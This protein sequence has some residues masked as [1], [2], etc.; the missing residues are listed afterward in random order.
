MEEN[1]R[2]MR[3]FSWPASPGL[4]ADLSVPP[5]CKHVRHFITIMRELMSLI[6]LLRAE[7]V[8]GSCSEPDLFSPRLAS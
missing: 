7:G 2:A 5:Q 6:P 4:V 1:R 3:G 8:S